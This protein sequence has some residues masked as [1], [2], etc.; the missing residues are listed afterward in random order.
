MLLQKFTV[1]VKDQQEAILFYC[2]KLG[3]ELLEDKQITKEKRYVVLGC[4][5]QKSFQ[6]VLAKA[7]ENE[8]SLIGKQAGGKVFFYLFSNN[9]EKDYELLK[10]NG[11]K[12][13]EEPRNE[14]HGKVVILEDLYGNKIDLIEPADSKF[15]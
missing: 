11:V 9:F 7:N 12:F 13:L 1:L 3:F 4:K 8:L 5:L 14:S 6:I 15:N 10:D 2:Q